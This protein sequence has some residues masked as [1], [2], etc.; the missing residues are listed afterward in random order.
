[1][2]SSFCPTQSPLAAAAELGWTSQ[3]TMS[4]PLRLG[5]ST[6]LMLACASAVSRVTRSSVAGVVLGGRAWVMGRLGRVIVQG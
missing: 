4:W 3:S 5:T 6:N 2:A 1:M